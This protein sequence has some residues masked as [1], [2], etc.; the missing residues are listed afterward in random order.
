MVIYKMTRKEK[1]EEQHKLWFD[2]NDL[3][4]KF[5]DARYYFILAGR[6]AGKTYSVLKRS[7]QD[8]IM[9]KGLF[10]YVRRYK[11]S[12]TDTFIQDL[13]K[14]H[15]GW[16]SDFTGGAWNRIGY[17]RKRWYLELWER[18]ENGDMQRTA[19]NPDPIGGAFAINTWE[20]SKGPDFGA[21]NGIKNIIFD[22]ALSK[23]GD[24]LTDEWGKWENV[25][26]S[27]VRDRTDKDTKIWLLANPVSKWNNCYF[28][29]LGITKKMY[30]GE[31]NVTLIKYPNERGGESTMSTV[32][33]YI[34]ARMDGTCGIDRDAVYDTY[35][36]FPNSK[37]IAK[38]ITD[39]MWEMDDANILPSQTY[40]NS[41]KNRTIYF[42]FQ[43]ELFACDVM[44]HDV[45]GLYYLFFHPTKELKE[46]NY[47]FTLDLE[48]NKYAIVG[49]KTGHP[50]ADLFNKIYRTGQV[51]YS[52]NMIADCFH[53]FL[54]EANKRII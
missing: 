4:E 41:V 38:S 46:K 22:E 26:S 20:T 50:I 10:A 17:W 36:A 23:G 44:R 13:L 11:D 8:A 5:P 43:E 12:I 16:L 24:Y 32:F 2:C 25:I 28:A 45:T 33:C 53:G 14:P 19:R 21:I 1:T 29:N 27:L 15:W 30:T 34:T 18:D 52:D 39:G 6:A 35:F 9:G 40:Q 31:D 7:I 3:L 47:Y 37:G 54:K 42:K 48:M 49:C 51:Y